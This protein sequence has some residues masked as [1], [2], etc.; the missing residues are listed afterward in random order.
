MLEHISKTINRVIEQSDSFYESDEWLKLR[1]K[2]IRKYKSTCMACGFSAP[3]VEIHVDHIRPRSTHKHLELDEDN[4]Q[5]LCRSC[6]LGKSNIFE[7]DWR[8]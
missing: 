5:I 8:E 6:N 7:D 2:V 3:R 1:Y 4:L